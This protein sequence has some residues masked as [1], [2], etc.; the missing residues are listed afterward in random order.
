[1]R[2]PENKTLSPVSM[3]FITLIILASCRSGAVGDGADG[4]GV[5]GAGKAGAGGRDLAKGGAAGGGAAGGATAGAGGGTSGSVAPPPGQTSGTQPPEAY[6]PK[7]KALL[8]GGVPTQG[9]IDMVKGDPT[10][11]VS[12]V[13]SWMSHP[14]F[15]EKMIRLFSE[16][17]QQQG[18]TAA[19]MIDQ[20]QFFNAAPKPWLPSLTTMF[21][22]TAWNIA[23]SDRPFTDTITTRSFM[24]NTALLVLLRFL[25]MSPDELQKREMTLYHRSSPGIEPPVDTAD[26][27]KRR[28]FFMPDAVTTRD[29]NGGECAD[30]AKVSHRVFF[31]F[32]LGLYATPN[33]EPRSA[34]VPFL[35]P[36]DFEDWRLVEFV[37]LSQSD[38]GIPYYDLASLRQVTRLSLKQPRLGFFTTPA[39]FARN[40]TN[41][42]NAFRVTT[43]Q[44]LIAA[45]GLAFDD[46]NVT[47]PTRSQ[48][49]SSEHA[50]PGTVCWACH[51]SLDPMRMYFDNEFLPTYQARASRGAG[52]ASFGF[53]GQTRDGGDLATFAEALST[54]PEFAFRWALRLCQWASSQPCA[55]DDPEIARISGIFASSG[56]RWKVLVREMM[57]SPLVTGAEETAT[58][59]QLSGTIVS[60]TRRSHLCTA[61]GTRLDL[62]GLCESD[63]FLARQIGIVPDDEYPR[64]ALSPMQPSQ[65]TV[66]YLGGMDVICSRIAALVVGGPP[67]TNRFSAD[68]PSSALDSFVTTVMG[69]PAGD[70]RWGPARK[71]L[72]DHMQSGGDTQQVSPRDSLRS[73]F[74]LAC[75]SPFTLGLGR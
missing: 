32:V 47:I 66:F 62:P 17:F 38:A 45:L 2:I 15:R 67:A 33:C 52:A 49:L 57:S 58:Q 69:L 23:E 63:P 18:I 16:A 75:T 8:N 34:S 41:E 19:D 1:M 35:A 46:E 3:P 26:S 24:V 50:E 5:G 71:I 13:D 22:R 29:P 65:A 64:G 44:A 74:T 4:P 56:H 70:A 61:L 30:P 72:E 53:Y 31:R 42:D 10:A 28:T 9:E 73:A 51:V 37:P 7:V 40:Q 55:E 48:A 43:N 36:A 6:V 11:L 21:A 12:L 14:G 60:I 20:V 27:V 68:E 39:F 25:D 59:S 54:H